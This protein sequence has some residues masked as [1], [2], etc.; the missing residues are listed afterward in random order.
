MKFIRILR[1]ELANF[2]DNACFDQVNMLL[3]GIDIIQKASTVMDHIENQLNENSHRDMEERRQ[4]ILRHAL[5]KQRKE[6]TNITQDTL[7]RL[8]GYK[9][10]SSIARMEMGLTRIS[11]EK[12]VQ[13]AE[14]IGMDR[15]VIDEIFTADAQ[16]LSRL[17]DNYLNPQETSQNGVGSGT[18]FRSQSFISQDMISE[19]EKI[20]NILDNAQGGLAK[21]DLTEAIRKTIGS[22]G[23][24]EVLDDSMEALNIPKGATIY[25]ENPQDL[26]DGDIGIFQIDNEL[27]VRKMVRS[28]DSSQ[29][30][31]ISGDLAKYPLHTFD[32]ENSDPETLIGR[33]S[34]V[35]YDI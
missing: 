5:K 25:Y 23:C 28:G 2:E 26:R 21:K 15:H 20:Q 30:L 27:M 32:L 12:A 17:E 19:N 10:R 13:W 34:S 14:R 7:A 16:S 31:L 8:L 9:N 33:V 35:S 29:L 11:Y 1:D 18:I 24:F 3:L 4:R 22:A 6:F